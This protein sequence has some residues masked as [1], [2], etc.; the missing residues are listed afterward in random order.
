MG[1]LGL[2][3]LADPEPADAVVAGHAGGTTVDVQVVRAVDVPRVST[4]RPIVAAVAKTV[5]L[6]R[7]VSTGLPPTR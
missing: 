1:L 5:H 2:L 4:R 7:V 3:E 6:T